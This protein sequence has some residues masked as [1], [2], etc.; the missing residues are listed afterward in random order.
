MALAWCMDEQ[1]ERFIGLTR[2]RYFMPHT[3]RHAAK[4]TGLEHECSIA[5]LAFEP[6]FEFPFYAD[7]KIIDPRMQMSRNAATG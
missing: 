7:E 4:S 3:G 2:I 1:E 5:V 6:D